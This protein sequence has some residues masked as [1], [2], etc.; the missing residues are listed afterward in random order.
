[1]QTVKRTQQTTLLVLKT[2]HIKI[3][4]RWKKFLRF[5]KIKRKFDSL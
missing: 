3:N 2:Q 1:M 4:E 5:H